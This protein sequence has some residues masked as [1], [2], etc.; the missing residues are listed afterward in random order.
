MVTHQTLSPTEKCGGET[1]PHK[2]VHA[3]APVE[4]AYRTSAPADETPEPVSDVYPG[5]GTAEHS[6]EECPSRSDIQYMH[7]NRL[8]K[9]LTDRQLAAGDTPPAVPISKDRSFLLANSSAMRM[10]GP[11][12]LLCSSW[13]SVVEFL[14]LDT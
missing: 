10:V 5:F 7:M 13:L 1:R 2:A 4:A 11:P 6:A 3:P 12:L 8:K 14:I 9:M